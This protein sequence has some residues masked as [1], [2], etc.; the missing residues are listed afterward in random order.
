MSSLKPFQSCLAKHPVTGSCAVPGDKSLSHRALIFASLAEGTTTITGL[1]ESGDVLCTARALQAMG[2]SMTRDEVS[3]DNA[4]W[5]V[6]G[7]GAAGLQEPETILDM[8]NSGTAA[9]LLTGV[10][11]GQ[12]FRS[13]ISGDHSLNKRP[14]KRVTEPLSQMGARFT[15]RQDEYLP[16]MAEGRAPLQAINYQSPVASAQVKSAILLAGLKADGITSVQEPHLSRDHTERMAAAFGWHIETEIDDKG[17][18]HIRTVGGQA[19]K[20]PQ[21]PL[22]IASDPSSAAFVMA[23]T[24]LIEG[25]DCLIKNVN[26][27]PTRTGFIQT[28]QDMGAVLSL[29][30]ERQQGGEPVAD[31]RVR[32][33]PDL[34]GVCV[35]EERVPSMIDEFPILS[36]VAACAQGETIMSGLSELRVKESDRLSAMAEGLVLCGASL[37]ESKD[38]LTIRG[39][40]V[41]PRGLAEAQERIMTHYDHRIAMSFLVLGAVTPHP[42]VVDD[43]SAIQTSFPAF[44]DMM[45]MLGLDFAPLPQ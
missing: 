3:D 45:P 42:V 31:I 16:M 2:V 6:I 39:E 4:Q 12:N 34:K 21:N 33:S 40:G 9:R 26:L 38:G 28:L 5:Q 23:A 8:G 25:S 11:A 37:E 7:A 13:F 32:Y 44:M 27:N 14:M 18:A 43:V 29:Q 10:L 19:L 24:A 30:N 22:V 1:L 35:P 20:A 41:P 15:A 17:A 36:V